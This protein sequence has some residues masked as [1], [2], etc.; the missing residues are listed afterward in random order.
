M[1]LLK[2]IFPR[3]E[4]NERL[5]ER[6]RRLEKGITEL[7]ESDPE[8]KWNYFILYLSA[9]FYDLSEHD[10]AYL[11]HLMRLRRKERLRLFAVLKKTPKAIPELK[12][13]FIRP[14]RLYFLLNEIPL[15]GLLLMTVLEKN[16]PYLRE[17]ISYYRRE[18]VHRRLL[19]NGDDLLEK[20]LTQG[21]VFNRVLK[22][23]HEAVLNGKVS[24]KEEELEY[25]SYLIKK[26]NMYQET[27][28]GEK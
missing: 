24:G 20:G 13:E 3:L 1:Q 4:F 26:N 12:K 15:E 23:L 10:T 18:L 9:L 6:L 14:A 22:S 5:K 27:G 7:V 16:D 2:V 28:E 25:L 17:H 21:P 11:C 8:G 19:T